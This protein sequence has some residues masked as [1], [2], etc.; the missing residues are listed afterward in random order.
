[1]PLPSHLSKSFVRECTAG[2]AVT[3]AIG[4]IKEM[5]VNTMVT[6]MRQRLHHSTI[7]RFFK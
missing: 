5:H 7:C 2:I 4:H 6:Y 1:M 3:I